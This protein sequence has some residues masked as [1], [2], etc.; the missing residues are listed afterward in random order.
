MSRRQLV[1]GIDGGG[2]KSIA[3]AADGLGNILATC[4]LGP[5]NPNVV[6]FEK[7]AKTLAQ[8]IVSASEEISCDVREYQS[9]VIGLSGAGSDANRE[10]IAAGING[11][12]RTK[13]PS[14]ALPVTVETDARVALEGAF[15][16]GSGVV[17][18]AGTGSIVL[19]KTPRGDV[20]RTGGWGRILGDEGSGYYIGREA[21]MAV[22][23]QMDK[24][25]DAGKL[26]EILA[27]KFGWKT[28]EEI[29]SAV[30]QEEFDIPSL[31]PLVF[32]A[33]VKNDIVSQRILQRAAQ[34]LSEQIRVVV[35]QLGILRKVGLVM[36]GGLIDHQTVYSNVLHM[37]IL[38]LL[39]QVE[40]RK[41]LHS[42]AH[43]A[44]LMARDILK[45][46]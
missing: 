34:Q 17:V 46:A 29:I 5:S 1:L 27:G 37:K 45:R 10:R 14:S 24:R 36:C 40:V 41:A 23:Q 28:R 20:L 42:P 22:T 9:I 30:Y 19:G 38:K 2:T 7:A 16:G 35:L 6:G 31:T 15:A 18:I 25:G 13:K 44:V 33:A 21:L 43:G 3:L 12:F 26:T 32:E 39:P 8:L 4:E 11:H